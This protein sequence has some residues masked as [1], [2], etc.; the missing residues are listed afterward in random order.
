MIKGTTLTSPDLPLDPHNNTIVITVTAENGVNQTE[1]N[2]YT[3]R[4]FYF[5][6]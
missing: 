3:Y 2:I 1:Y 4:G 5:L 6:F